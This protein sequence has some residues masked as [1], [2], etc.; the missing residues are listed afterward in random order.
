MNR[1]DAEPDIERLIQ[2]GALRTY[3]QPIVSVRRKSIAGV[4]SLLR[5]VHPET[6]QIL[7]PKVLFEAATR[8][9][10]FRRLDR[11][12]RSES[13]RLF[14][15]RALGEQ[16]LLFINFDLDS[17][18]HGDG[19]DELL[20]E[21]RAL[22]VP[23]SSIVAEL[24][25]NQFDDPRRLEKFV[26]RVREHGM[27]V[28]IDDVGA[29]HSN[30]ERIS[31]I[32]PDILKVDRSLCAKLGD[33]QCTEEVF[34]SLVNL[35]RRI[36]AL[37]VA[38]GIETHKQAMV[39]L[40]RGAELLQGYL[41]L[42]PQPGESLDMEQAE[43]ATATLA[44]H[45]RRHMTATINKN[46]TERRRQHTLLDSIVGELT[47]ADA[48][49]FERT[50]ARCLSGHKAAECAYV[51]DQSGQQVTET[52]FAD[53]PP[54]STLLFR[55]AEP[56]TDHSLKTYYHQLIDSEQSRYVTE[57]YVSFAS[58]KPCRT[59]SSA[60][61]DASNEQMFILCVDVMAA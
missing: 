6:N 60:F 20:H 17:I 43:G 55:P 59:I 49:N 56:G 10:C 27:L 51:L 13:L 32:R 58:G 5:A 41:V 12:A 39:A 44:G 53:G 34:T 9:N 61:R 29:G 48:A 36:G 16:C 45:F 15:D 2:D 23:P 26:A 7:S 11:A 50:L 37:V 25:E 24:V 47:Q 33:D 38:E 40:E 19:V 31:L 54:L 42:P 57:R 35:G 22:D 14:A 52:I 18:L 1:V 21:I 46:K 28:A 3:L 4:E 30:L 8:Q